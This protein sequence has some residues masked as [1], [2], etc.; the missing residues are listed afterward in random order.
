MTEMNQNPPRPPM[1]Q[2]RFSGSSE[3]DKENDVFARGFYSGVI[4]SAVIAFI[5]VMT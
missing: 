4:F 3:I 1:P 2:Y 5:V